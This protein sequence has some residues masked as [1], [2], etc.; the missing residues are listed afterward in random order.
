MGT[1]ISTCVTQGLTHRNYLVLLL[2]LLEGFIHKRGMILMREILTEIKDGHLL[3]SM[4]RQ[5]QRRELSQIGGRDL[6]QL[7]PRIK[8][9][10]CGTL[11]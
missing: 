8:Y 3:M 2:Q 9:S 1:L 5:T 6:S 4:R 7:T 10:A 11:M